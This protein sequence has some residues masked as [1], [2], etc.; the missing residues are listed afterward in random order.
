MINPDITAIIARQEQAMIAFR[1]DLHAHPELPGRRSARR[2]A[3]P[4][5][6]RLSVSL[7]A[8]LIPPE[9]SPTSSAASR[10]KP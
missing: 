3:S 10:V 1:R 6:W 4:P 2:I 5:N 8:A 9:S 7:I